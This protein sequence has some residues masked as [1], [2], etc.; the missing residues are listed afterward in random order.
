MCYKLLK[1][2]FAIIL[3][4]WLCQISLGVKF[5][6]GKCFGCFAGTVGKNRK[7]AEIMTFTEFT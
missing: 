7:I 6:S 3:Y 4:P 1:L 5:E 2:Y